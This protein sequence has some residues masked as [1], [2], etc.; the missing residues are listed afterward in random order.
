MRT[1][2]L[3]KEKILGKEYLVFRRRDNTSQDYSLFRFNDLPFSLRKKIKLLRINT[4]NKKTTVYKDKID[5]F[6]SACVIAY[7][8]VKKSSIIYT[9]DAMFKIKKNQNHFLILDLSFNEL[10]I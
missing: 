9:E 5:S 4:S 3:K 7:N 6:N 1:K 8:T 2:C 10:D